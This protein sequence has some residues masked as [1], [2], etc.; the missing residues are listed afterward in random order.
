MKSARRQTESRE[1]K[2][3]KRRGREIRETKVGR[4]KRRE[5]GKRGG[6]ERGWMEERRRV[7]RGMRS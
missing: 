1:N 2:V 6:E 4:A 5:N 7:K 3:K